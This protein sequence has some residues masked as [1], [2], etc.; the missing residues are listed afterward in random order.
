MRYK[1]CVECRANGKVKIRYIV[2]HIL[3]NRN[4]IMKNITTI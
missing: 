4:N 1:T 3:R 2:K